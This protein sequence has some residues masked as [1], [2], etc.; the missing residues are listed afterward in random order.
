MLTLT[1]IN[2]YIYSSGTWWR[3]HI[4]NTLPDMEMSVL[5]IA[6][7]DSCAKRLFINTWSMVK[8]VES[9]GLREARLADQFRDV[10]IRLQV[11]RR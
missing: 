5:N 7:I 3:Q 9:Q 10:F 2:M 6:D 11:S 8:P 4:L 1:G